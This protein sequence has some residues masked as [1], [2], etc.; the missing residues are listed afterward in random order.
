MCAKPHIPSY[1]TR[2]GVVAFENELERIKIAAADVQ[3]NDG[4]I[5]S[6]TRSL[7]H[8]ARFTD[9]PANANVEVRRQPRFAEG[10]QKT[11]KEGAYH[12]HDAPTQTHANE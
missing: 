1:L 6:P 8:A 10:H 3:G 12:H 11:E 9:D 2:L 7:N 5:R 4:Q